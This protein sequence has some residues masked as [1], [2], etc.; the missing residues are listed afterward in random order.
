MIDWGNPNWGLPGHNVHHAE[1][2]SWVDSHNGD[3]E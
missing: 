2:G 3:R 1:D